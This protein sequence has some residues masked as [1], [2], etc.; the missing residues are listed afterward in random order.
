[1]AT[2]KTENE[3]SKDNMSSSE[4]KELLEEGMLSTASDTSTISGCPSNWARVAVQQ[5][6]SRKMTSLKQS[7]DTLSDFSVNSIIRTES[8]TPHEH[9]QQNISNTSENVRYRP[10]ECVDN[11]TKNMPLDAYGDIPDLSTPEQGLPPIPSDRRCSAPVIST[12]THNKSTSTNNESDTNSS[13]LTVPD[14][15]TNNTLPLRTTTSTVPHISG[16]VL[17][18]WPHYNSVTSSNNSVGHGS[19]SVFQNNNL[20]DALLLHSPEKSIEQAVNAALS[21][22]ER[23]MEDTEENCQELSSLGEVCKEVNTEVKWRKNRQ[24]NSI[25]DEINF[26]YCCMIHCVRFIHTDGD[27]Y[28]LYLSRCPSGY[29]SV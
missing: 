3:Y 9:A 8:S 13:I 10:I 27:L 26:S 16:S 5:E 22:L 23:D 7:S 29:Q 25:T 6:S 12:S 19:T 11:S 14:A 18:S 20:V 1:M 2:D 17:S 24:V 4:H 15:C 28:P 21:S